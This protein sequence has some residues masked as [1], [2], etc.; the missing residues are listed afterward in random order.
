MIWKEI[1]LYDSWKRFNET[2][3]C[4]QKYD[5]TDI[6]RIQLIKVPTGIELNIMQSNWN[7]A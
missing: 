2:E 4:T 6:F 1:L 3:I 7:H 5:P